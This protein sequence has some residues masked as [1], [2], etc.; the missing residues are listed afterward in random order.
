MLT[1]LRVRNFKRFESMDIDLGNPVVFIGPNNSGK[2]TAMQALALWELGL[3]RWHEKRGGQSPSAQRSGVPIYRGDVFALTHPTTAH[4]WTRRRTRE[5]R[6]EHGKVSTTNI[7]IDIIV[8]GASNGRQWQCGLEFDY[9][10][11]D[12]IYCRPLRLNNARRPERM[13]VPDEAVGSRIAYLPPMS[14]L[15]DPEP[16][17]SPG[18][19]NVR[20]GQG[21]TAEVLRNLCLLVF[22]KDREAWD[23]LVHQIARCFGVELEPPV[24]HLR[25]GEISLAYV[26]EGVHLDVS[27]AGRG[28]HQTLLVLAYLYANRGAVLMMDEPDAHLEI[29]RQ[30]EIYD[31]LVDA[32]RKTG[33][34]LIA[35]SHSEVLL[36]E[37]AGKD[38]VI[39]FVGQPQPLGAAKSQVLKALRGIG[40]DQ[41][42]SAKRSGWVLYLEGST[43][44][45][46]LKS[47]SARLGHEDATV[48][49]DRPFVRY[50]G[51]SPSRANEHFYGLRHA[52]P[53]LRGIAIYDWLDTVP[54]MSGPLKHLTWRRREIENYLCTRR[55]LEAFA[56]EFDFPFEEGTIFW[57]VEKRRRADAM[58]ECIDDLCQALDTTG[59]GSPW[60][61]DFKVSDL[62]LIPLFR[63]FFKQLELPNL[64]AKK[65]FYE[66]A[67]FVPEEEIDP[68]IIEKLDAIA[69]IAGI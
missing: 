44:R 30:R 15:V 68:E 58:R 18:S 60:D 23:L 20:V 52:M 66:L 65:S 2:T 56:V 24:L 45:A 35:A 7:R 37:A 28:L 42:A 9:S 53:D 61:D 36:N 33:G 3:T 21:R 12:Q 38:L 67:Q 34:Q 47:F 69:N 49:L 39:S 22:K 32:A 17:L 8:D 13:A 27:A 26:E 6:S 1:R 29:L 31:M 55:T 5:G 40:H 4:F 10:N 41:Y 16:L 57:E 43:D 62:F 54:E 46:I 19:I 48:A 11:E 59:Q 63:N 51:N 14:G 64:M 25:T 50:V